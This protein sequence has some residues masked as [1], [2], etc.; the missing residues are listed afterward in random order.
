MGYMGLGTQRWI[1]TMKPRKFFE[2][3]SKPDGGGGNSGLRSNVQDYYHLKKNSLSNL[4]RKK[5][6]IEYKRLLGKQ[7]R[8]ENQR[9]QVYILLSFIIALTFLFLLFFYLNTKFE[10]F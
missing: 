4:K 7:L 6:T 9:Q 5:Y 3:R 10:W 2:K 1:S 8:E